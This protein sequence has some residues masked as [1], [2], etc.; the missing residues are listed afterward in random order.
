[1]VLDYSGP[2]SA[3]DHERL[4][5]N[6]V[7]GVPIEQVGWLGDQQAPSTSIHYKISRVTVAGIE[8]GS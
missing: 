1:M 3:G 7:T 4:I 5:I 8:S 2:P 6:S